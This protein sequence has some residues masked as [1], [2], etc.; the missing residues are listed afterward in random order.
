MWRWSSASKSDCYFQVCTHPRVLIGLEQI[1]NFGWFMR[2]KEGKEKESRGDS[3]VHRK[4][5]FV[6]WG[7]AINLFVSIHLLLFRALN[8]CSY[9]KNIFL[10]KLWIKKKIHPFPPPPLVLFLTLLLTQFIYLWFYM[11]ILKY[12][13]FSN[14]SFAFVM[15]LFFSYHSF[16]SSFVDA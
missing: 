7:N 8:N 15:F 16:L 4:Q 12:A 13:H 5:V 14:F 1:K 9:I 2:I 6:S 10:Y 3:Q 11:C